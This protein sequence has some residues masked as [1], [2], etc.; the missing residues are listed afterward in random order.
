MKTLVKKKR[1]VILHRGLIHPLGISGPHLVPYWENIEIIN[2]LIMS[3]YKVAEVLKDGTQIVLDFTNYD[4]ENGDPNDPS[5]QV[6]YEKYQSLSARRREKD[7]RVKSIGD[8]NDPRSEMHK[9]LKKSTE[10]K[11]ANQTTN[12][13]V[14]ANKI[15]IDDSYENTYKR[16]E[17]D[18]ID[19]I[20]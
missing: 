7:K 13:L 2:K 19:D 18:S 4:K 8:S 16:P 3:G 1:I 15:V 10:Q 14:N 5:M 11:P 20:D 9:I 17:L 12:D 6:A